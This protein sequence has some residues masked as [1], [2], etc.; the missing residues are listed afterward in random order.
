MDGML[1]QDEINALLTGMDGGSS[2]GPAGSNIR[3]G[4]LCCQ[5]LLRRM[6]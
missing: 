3:P 6:L 4:P 5:I 2:N 1:T